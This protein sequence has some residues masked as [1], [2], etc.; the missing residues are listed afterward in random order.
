MNTVRNKPGNNLPRVL[1]L[2]GSPHESGTTAR[3]LK[4]F[5]QPLEGICEVEM[6]RAFD[7]PLAP[8]TGCRFCERKQGC[9]QKDFAVLEQKVRAAEVLVLA[10][11]VYFLSYPAPMKAVVDRFQCYWGMRFAHGIR[12][13]YTPRKTGVLLACAGSDDARCQDILLQQTRMAF[14]VVDADIKHAVFW[15]GTDQGNGEEAD[16][17]R[18]A[19]QA[20][21]TVKA[22]LRNR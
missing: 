21:E 16:A 5:L 18:Q 13:V 9:S 10:T 6:L 2:F 1:V 17:L 7:Q 3:L 12:P 15:M 19:R 22:D 8:C 11:P 14:S 20:G 4:A